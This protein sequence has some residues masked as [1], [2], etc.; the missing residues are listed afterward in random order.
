[1]V[2]AHSLTSDG[3]LLSKWL[4]FHLH[5]FSDQE[6]LEIR[7]GVDGTNKATFGGLDCVLRAEALIFTRRTAPL[8]RDLSYRTY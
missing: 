1:M 2:I 5:R 6:K 3:E 4:S 8:L 7:L